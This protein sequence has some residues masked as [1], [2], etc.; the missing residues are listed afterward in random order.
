[1]T[2]TNGVRT[3]TQ[4]VTVAVDPGIPVAGI[5]TVGGPSSSTGVVSGSAA[6]TDTAGRTL[7]Y[8]ASTTSTGGG[9]VTVNAA[10]GAYTYTPTPTQRQTATATTTDTFTVTAN[11]GVRSATATIT[12][13]VS[14]SPLTAPTIQINTVEPLSGTVKLSLSGSVSGAV[15]WYADLK[16]IGAANS[17]DGYSVSW[18]TGNISNGDHQILALIQTGPDTVQQAIAKYDIKPSRTD[19]YI[20]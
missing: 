11:N 3:A 1:V 4:T 19:P 12:V 20:V 6:F 7:S 5:A 15:T 16:L 14:A 2:A 13:P 17:A 8:T 18:P 10:T 9:T